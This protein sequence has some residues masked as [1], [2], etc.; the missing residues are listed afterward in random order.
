METRPIQFKEANGTLAGQT[1]D[2][3]DLPVYRDGEYVISCWRIP[4]WKRLK[5]LWSGRVFLAVQGHTH[6]P[7]WVDTEAFANPPG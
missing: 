2:V 7:L 5:V 3:G 6:A 4:F 1:P